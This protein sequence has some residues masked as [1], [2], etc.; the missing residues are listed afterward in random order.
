MARVLGEAARY[1][2]GQSLK[3]YKRQFIA[4][5]LASFF[6]ALV[7]GIW[8]GLSLNKHSYVWTAI[9]IFVIALIFVLTIRLTDKVSD[10]LERERKQ[11]QEGANL[12]L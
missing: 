9:S 10:R 2:T 7:I 4:I 8:L 5:L 3:K 1:V 6:L 11:E 12:H